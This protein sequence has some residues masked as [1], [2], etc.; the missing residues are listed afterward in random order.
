MK[1]PTAPFELGKGELKDFDKGLTGTKANDI[2][3]ISVSFP[4]DFISEQLAGK[5]GVFTVKVVKVSEKIVPEFNEEF[6]LKQETLKPL[7]SLKTTSVRTLNARN[8]NVQKM[9]P[10]IKS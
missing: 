6:F 10:M 9:K 7:M 8:K 3:D 2:V 5:K 1:S 4:K